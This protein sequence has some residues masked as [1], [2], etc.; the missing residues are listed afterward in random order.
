[1]RQNNKWSRDLTLFCNPVQIASP[2][3]TLF[4]NPVQIAS[5]ILGEAICTGFWG[6]LGILLDFG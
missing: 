2:R 4:C 5:P 6:F 1:V 3:I